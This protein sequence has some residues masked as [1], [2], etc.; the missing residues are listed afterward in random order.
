MFFMHKSV[1]AIVP[2]LIIAL[3]IPK[4]PTN[5]TCTT[6]LRGVFEHDQKREIVKEQGFTFMAKAQMCKRLCTTSAYM[7]H[8][9]HKHGT[10]TSPNCPKQK[11]H[12][13]TRLHYLWECMK[14]Q[15]FWVAV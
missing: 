13:G 9:Y 11:S 15:M 3:M 7:H 14:I 1:L 4:N 5:T 2:A 12:V 8:I 10:A 6:C